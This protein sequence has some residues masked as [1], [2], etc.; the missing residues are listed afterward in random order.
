VRAGANPDNAGQYKVSRD[1]SPW[2]RRAAALNHDVW[3]C[4]GH[5][6][7]YVTTEP[8]VGGDGRN[9]QEF[10]RALRSMA[11]QTAR[12]SIRHIKVPISDIMST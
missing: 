12:G 7:D 8:G 1:H 4:S 2:C 10:L 3:I 11:A 6:V 5:V 9:G